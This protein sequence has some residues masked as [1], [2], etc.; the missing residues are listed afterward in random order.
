M[1]GHRF[2]YISLIILRRLPSDRRWKTLFCL[3]WNFA[4]V[5]KNFFSVN[6]FVLLTNQF[7]SRSFCLS[8]CNF[9]ELPTYKQKIKTRSRVTSTVPISFF[10]MSRFVQKHGVVITTQLCM[11]SAHDAI[12]VLKR[13]A[14]ESNTV[15]QTF[16]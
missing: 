2:V 14:N 15:Q 12:Q 11:V 4:K 8:W 10:D 16:P 5:G 3:L 9:V 6:H 7:L 1:D 13:V